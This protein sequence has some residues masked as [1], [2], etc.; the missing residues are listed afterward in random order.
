MNSSIITLTTS[1]ADGKGRLKVLWWERNLWKA[2]W[3]GKDLAELTI[4]MGTTGK[5]EIIGREWG[6]KH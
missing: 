5:E 6:M 3:L 4:Q 1:S 2:V